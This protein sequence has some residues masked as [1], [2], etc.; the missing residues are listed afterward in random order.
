M[1][2]TTSTIA[3]RWNQHKRQKAP[4]CPLL[5]RALLKYGPASFEVEELGR[6][7]SRQE[8]DNAERAYIAAFRANDPQFGYNLTEG[9]EGGI[10]GLETRLKISIAKKGRPVH[11]PEARLQMSLSRRGEKHSFYGKHHSEET[12]KKISISCTGRPG[13]N[14]GRPVSEETRRKISAANQGKHTHSEEQ[15]QKWSEER[16]GAKHPLYGTK[17]INSL[18]SRLKMSQSRTGKRHSPESRLKISRSLTGKRRS[19]ETIEKMRAVRV[20][21]K[22]VE[23][24]VT[25][26]S[27]KD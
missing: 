9:G 18:E 10:P 2:Q 6:A 12:R 14:K 24:G 3:C 27:N 7:F 8:L 13:P 26:C 19:P 4:K 16:K 21:R 1:G 25:R 22:Q 5:Q 11:S 23:G 20:R 17:R 15:K